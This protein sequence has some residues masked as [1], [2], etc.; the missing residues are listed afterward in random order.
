M[1]VLEFICLLLA[2]AFA[3]VALGSASASL[4]LRRE[5][6]RLRHQIGEERV[7]AHDEQSR[8]L[9]V[10]VTEAGHDV[11]LKALDAACARETV[12]Q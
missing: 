7:A 10:V 1:T 3:V 2:L 11:A 8:I 12:I 4:A 9:A 6:R 5:I